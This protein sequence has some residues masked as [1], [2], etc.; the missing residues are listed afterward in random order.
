MVIRWQLQPHWCETWYLIRVI[1][2]EGLVNAG[3]ELMLIFR[4]KFYHLGSSEGSLSIC[5]RTTKRDLMWIWLDSGKRDLLW[6]WLDSDKQDLAW[7]GIDL[8]WLGLD[9]DS[10]ATPTALV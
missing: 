7:I 8:A 2:V 4:S 6:I 9:S 5:C 10:L 3:S 1:N